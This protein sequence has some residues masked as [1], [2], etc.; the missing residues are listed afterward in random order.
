MKKDEPHLDGDEIRAK[1]RKKMEKYDDR[2]F[3]ENVAMYLGVAQIL[4]LG[5]KNLL[6]R[7]YDYE[8]D[9]LEKFTLGR[10]KNE[11]ERCGLRD[12]YLA[13]VESVVESRNYIAHE[14]LAN[15]AL[16]KSIVGDSG[17]KEQRILWKAIY[18][19]EQAVFLYDWCEEHEA[20]D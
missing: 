8:F 1:V 17:T 6:V 18:E 13:L 12:D 15:D 14:M 2:S 16:V 7:K 4:E 5:L 20:W 19:L 11:L 10:T 3:L 9:D